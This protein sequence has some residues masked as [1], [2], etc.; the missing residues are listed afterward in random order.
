MTSSNRT[1][2]SRNRSRTPSRNLTRNATY[3][4][5]RRNRGRRVLSHPRLTRAIRGFEPTPQRP[6]ES[7]MAYINRLNDLARPLIGTRSEAPADR[8]IYEEI[9]R[10]RNPVHLENNSNN[11]HIDPESGNIPAGFKPIRLPRPPDLGACGTNVISG[12]NFD[13]ER[14]VLLSDGNC[15]DYDILIQLYDAAVDAPRGEDGR[16]QFLSPYT[17][18]PFSAKDRKVVFTLKRMAQPSPSASRSRR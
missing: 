18:A 3:N 13:P 8:F 9:D 15:Y 5:S 16:I 6:G 7:D 12:G 14:T 4:E 10:L 17:R 2:R 11:G 1:R